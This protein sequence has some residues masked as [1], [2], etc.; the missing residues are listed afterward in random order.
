MTHDKSNNN[1]YNR[2]NTNIKMDAIKEKRSEEQEKVVVE[3]LSRQWKDGDLL[4]ITVGKQYP[5][6]IKDVFCEIVDDNNEKKT[7]HIDFF[8][9]VEKNT[10]KPLTTKEI[11]FLGKGGTM[12]MPEWV[13]TTLF[14]EEESTALKQFEK[15][16]PQLADEFKKIQQENYE[17]F[18]G[19]H[20]DYG[21]KNISQGEDMTSKEGQKWALTG[22]FFRMN[23]KISRWKNLMTRKFKGEINNEPLTDTWADLSNYGVI[24]RMVDEGKWI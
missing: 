16:Y 12:T 8:K 23:D 6:V 5:A 24:A 4:N 7:Y 10:P 20:L 17:L 21:M 15:E 22:L 11:N 2:T 9:I 13:D 1:F 19:K 18:A 3:C 14:I